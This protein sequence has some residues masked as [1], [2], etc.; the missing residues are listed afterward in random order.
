MT[1][2]GMSDGRIFTNYLPNCQLNNMIQSK[3][4]FTNNVEY[5]K[6]I[7]NNS[8][9]VRNSFTQSNPAPVSGCALPGSTIKM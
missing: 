1:R 3:N 2:P 7:Q 5:K 4:Q 6:F 8:E 9:Q